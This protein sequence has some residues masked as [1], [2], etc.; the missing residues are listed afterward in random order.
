[1]DGLREDYPHN[2]MVLNGLSSIKIG[3]G[4]VE[5]LATWW[6]WFTAHCRST[7][8]LFASPIFREAGFEST[9]HC[10]QNR[11]PNQT[12]PL[13]VDNSNWK[14]SLTFILH[15]SS[16]R[17][18]K[19]WKLTIFRCECIFPERLPVCITQFKI[20]QTRQSGEYVYP[21]HTINQ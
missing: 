15:L 3:N 19:K 4:G 14:I 18:I 9:T 5:P 11:C 17:N 10:I 13:S 21:G 12:G 16:S 1:M 8:A 7:P 6:N 20:T 2:C